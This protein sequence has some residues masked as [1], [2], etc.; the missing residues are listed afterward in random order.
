MN[1]GGA[2]FPAL[3]FIIPSDLEARHVARLGET[4]GMSLRDYFAAKAMQA[5]AN[6]T[7]FTYTEANETAQKAYEYADAMLAQRENGKT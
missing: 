5:F 2:A 7:V 4:Q 6:G 1:D 3:N